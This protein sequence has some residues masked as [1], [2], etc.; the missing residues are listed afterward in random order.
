MPDELDEGGIFRPAQYSPFASLIEKART[1]IGESK[2][3]KK[4]R[5]HRSRGPPSRGWFWLGN[6]CDKN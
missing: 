2:V 6:V 4:M 3:S 1:W 5:M